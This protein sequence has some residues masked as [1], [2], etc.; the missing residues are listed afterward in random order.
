MH[1]SLR[2]TQTRNSP[3]YNNLANYAPDKIISD[4]IPLANNVHENIHP[5]AIYA[6]VPRRGPL[7]RKACE[8]N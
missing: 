5:V 2:K 8:I 3:L 7:N 6:I 1:V 4:I